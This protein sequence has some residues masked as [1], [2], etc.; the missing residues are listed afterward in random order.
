M[1]IGP[2]DWQSLGV[3]LLVR[4]VFLAMTVLLSL[5]PLEASKRTP[6]PTDPA[7]LLAM[8]TLLRVSARC[9]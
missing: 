7:L 9:A 2:S 6:P 4:M 3:G 1:T 5:K 8:E